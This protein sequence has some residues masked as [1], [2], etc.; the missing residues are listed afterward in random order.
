MPLLGQIG[1][2]MAFLALKSIITRSRRI[3]VEHC[4]S[5]KDA[6]GQ[7]EQKR[8]VDFFSENSSSSGKSRFMLNP[9][10]IIRN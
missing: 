7:A 5:E 9:N 3:S 4:N 6:G 8:S 1:P 10:E 2:K